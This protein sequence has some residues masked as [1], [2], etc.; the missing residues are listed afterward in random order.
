MFI[1]WTNTRIFIR[2]G[3]T[4]MRKQSG[5]LSVLVEQELECDP[6]SGSL[7]LFCNRRRNLMKVLYW[8]RNGFCLWGK[9]L[10]KHRFPWPDSEEAVRKS[11]GV[12]WILAD[13]ENYRTAASV[14]NQI[15]RVV[16]LGG[17]EIAFLYQPAS[18]V[19]IVRNL[20]GSGPIAGESAT[21]HRRRGG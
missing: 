2:P 10:E 8:D 9:K 20:P 12:D 7:Y 19:V 1:D 18:L 6:F 4:D 5:G 13:G 11:E 15:V 3:K 14:R 16:R 17:A 21:P